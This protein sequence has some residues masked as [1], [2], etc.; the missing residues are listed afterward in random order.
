MKASLVVIASLFVSPAYAFENLIVDSTFQYPV[1]LTGKVTSWSDGQL[2]GPLQGSNVASQNQNFSGVPNFPTVPNFPMVPNLP[3]V[4]S[5]VAEPNLI[6]VPNLIATPNLLPVPNPLVSA[7]PLS[8]GAQTKPPGNFS[9]SQ[10]GTTSSNAPQQL[11]NA[12]PTASATQTLAASTSP[13]PQVSSNVSP[14]ASASRTSAT[15]SSPASQLLS[16][17]SP[18]ASATQTLATSSSA[19]S[20]PSP[21]VSPT[22]S[23]TQTLVTSSS[24]ALQLLSNVSVASATQALATSSS[25]AP[26]LLSNVS[27]VASATQALATSS[28]PAPQLLSNVSPVASATQTLAT[29]SSPA[30][31]LLSN[32]SP[33]ASATQTLATPSSPASQL[34]SNVSPVALATLAASN[35]RYARLGTANVSGTATNAAGE[36]VAGDV[37]GSRGSDKDFGFGARGGAAAGNGLNQTLTSFK[38]TKSM[39][40]ASVNGGDR[41]GS[42]HGADG[43]ANLASNGVGS[44]STAAGSPAGGADRAG[45]FGA[46][47]AAAIATLFS[48]GESGGRPAAPSS[49]GVRGAPGPVA[50]AGLPFLCLFVGIAYVIAR[51]RRRTHY[52]QCRRISSL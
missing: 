20:Q 11:S 45:H 38:N 50:G 15:S 48:N 14:T 32:F 41:G 35:A 1:V 17:V 40:L 9:D 29:S 42:N 22:A 10:L 3:A 43:T 47:F 31:Q 7:S 37:R 25:P 30:P 49:G 44:F 52:E 2:I 12:S 18:V 13:A 51:R 21:N 5:L 34:L 16:N 19:A 27:P 28:S 4:P 24:A 46:G 33:A 36:F 23:A 6:P 8:L 39:T 26:Q